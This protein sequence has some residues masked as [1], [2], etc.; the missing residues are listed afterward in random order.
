MPIAVA[1]EVLVRVVGHWVP[2]H[3][4]TARQKLLSMLGLLLQSSNNGDASQGNRTKDAGKCCTVRVRVETASGLVV[5]QFTTDTTATVRDVKVQ[6]EKQAPQYPVSDQQLLV[7]GHER[8]GVL[9]DAGMF[10]DVVEVI[11]KLKQHQEENDVMVDEEPLPNSEACEALEAAEAEP[12]RSMK[13]ELGATPNKSTKSKDK[14]DDDDGDAKT[15][16]PRQTTVDATIRQLGEICLCLTVAA[17]RWSPS[18]SHSNCTL[19]HER[20]RIAYVARWTPW[21]RGVGTIRLTRPGHFYTVRV[22][23][24]PKMPNRV[25]FGLACDDGCL[26][27]YKPPF[28]IFCGGL[29]GLQ[30]RAG[31]KI[32]RVGRVMKAWRPGDTVRV[33]LGSDKDGS[34]TVAYSIN[35]DRVHEMVAPTGKSTSPPFVPFCTFPPACVLDMEDGFGDS[36]SCQ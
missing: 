27:E 16:R 22:V 29:P 14:A 5:A 2:S 35:G 20:R 12:P 24:L 9:Q 26:P 31:N 19:S 6:V 13:A 10:C 11:L 30:V 21:P 8:H 15:Q 4:S 1:K 33:T 34:L 25:V 3:C 23:E 32:V 28:A 18:L 17:A 36:M 7:S